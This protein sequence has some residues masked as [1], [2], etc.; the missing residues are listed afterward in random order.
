[1]VVDDDFSVSLGDDVD[2]TDCFADPFAG[3]DRLALVDVDMRAALRVRLAFGKRMG[4]GD[5][6]ICM[7]VHHFFSSMT[8]FDDPSLLFDILDIYDMQTC[9]VAVESKYGHN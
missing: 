3:A 9:V 7:L 4:T 1:M 5:V 8:L 6:G 2:D